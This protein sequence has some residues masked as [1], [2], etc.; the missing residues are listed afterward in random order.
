MYNNNLFSKIYKGNTNLIVTKIIF[1][2]RKISVVYT[3]NT[4]IFYIV[5]KISTF[6]YILFNYI[7]YKKFFILNYKK[8]CK[9]IHL[10]YKIIIYPYY[11]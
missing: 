11:F 5:M 2:L 6:I 8:K 9:T 10:K 1:I 3:Q 7:G 4:I